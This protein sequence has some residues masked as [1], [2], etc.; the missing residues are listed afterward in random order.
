MKKTFRLFFCLFVLTACAK[1]APT[2]TSEPELSTPIPVTNT[3]IPAT[4]ISTTT[5]QPTEIILPTST[6]TR[7]FPPSV[8]GKDGMTLLYVPAG[9]FL[10]GIKGADILA[11]CQKLASYCNLNWFDAESPQHAVYLNAFRI[12]QTEVT[13]KMYLACVKAGGCKP[14]ERNISHTRS[15]YYGNGEFYNYPV[16]F[17]DWNM[18]KAYCEWA[19]RRLPTDAEWEKAARGID[20]RLYPWGNN[21]PEENMLNYNGKYGYSRNTFDGDTTKVGSFPVDQSPYGAFD[22]AGNVGEWVA[23]W[24][25]ES[26]YLD[27]PLSN[28]LGPVSGEGRVQRGGLWF[29]PPEQVYIFG[30]NWEIPS[31]ADDF[32]G[33]RC[34]VDMEE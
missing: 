9:E 21:V 6:S 1:S 22:M 27:S 19:G 15:N 33:F 31:V 5:P 26:Y 23:D 13:T 34:A 8:I 10:M 29:S 12:D 30:R 11:D 24:Y 3:T 20:G 28:P 25:S 7:D 17:V 4:D 32:T 16:V 14:L 2:V 18:A